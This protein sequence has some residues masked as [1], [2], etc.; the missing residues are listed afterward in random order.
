MSDIKPLPS[1][2]MQRYHGWKAT[3]HRQNQAWY[4][5]LATEGQRPREMIISCSDSRVH[6]AAMFGSDSDDI[7]VHRNIAAVVP[8]YEAHGFP[9]STS[10]SIEYA[11]RSLRVNHIVVLGHSNC[12]GVRSCY[13]MCS[14]RAPDLENATNF[15]G[16]W[17]DTLRPA[18]ER[19]PKEKTDDAAM[20]SLL[21]RESIKVSLENLLTFPVIRSAVDAEEITL[22]G[23]WIDI[24]EGTLEMYDAERNRFVTV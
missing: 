15:V 9:H 10:A 18:F 19:L 22:H 5:R 17:L 21:E 12:G 16:R 14:G 4:R 6:V 1:Y 24:G 11:V 13:D 20:C 2:L 3:T 8:P 23:L 7:F